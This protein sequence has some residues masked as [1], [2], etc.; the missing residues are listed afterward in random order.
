MINQACQHNTPHPVFISES[1][2]APPPTRMGYL[3]EHSRSSARPKPRTTLSSLLA[4]CTVVT[5]LTFLSALKLTYWDAPPVARPLH[6]DETILKCQAL[7][8][9]P[10]PPADFHQRTVSDRFV[11][12]TKSVLIRNASIWTGEDSGRESIHGDIFIHNGIIQSIGRVDLDSHF[13]D[14]YDAVSIIDAA[15]SWV[16]PGIIDLHSHLGVDSVPELRG[17]SDTNSR[18]GIAQPWLRSLDGLNTRDDAYRLSISGG[19]T[20]AVV[21]PGSANDIGGQ[22]FPIK[23]RPTAER[24]PTS[25]LLEA[26][27]SINDTRVDP[28]APP[29]WRHM[30]YACG[31][32]PMRVY[33]NTRMDNIWA[34]REAHNTARQLKEKQDAYCSKALAG[35]WQGLGEF[36]DDLQWEALVDVLRGRVKVHNHCYETVDLDDL[37]RLTNEFQFPIAAFHH[38]HE[39][40]LVPSTLKKAYGNTP[41]AAIFA[42]NARYKREAYRGS[43]FAARILAD[44]GIDVVMKSDHPVLNSRYL[45]YEAQQAHYYGLPA[46]L[47]LASV[48]S[49]PAKVMGTDHRIGFVREG[50]DADLVLWDSHPLNLGATPQQVWIDGIAQLD[51]PHVSLKTSQLQH[52]PQT[53]NF[54][55]QAAEAVKFEGLQPLSPARTTAETVVFTNVG[56]VFVRNGGRIEEMIGLTD[57]EPGVVVVRKGSIVCQGSHIT[58]ASSTAAVAAAEW[59][60]LKGGSISPGLTSF[61]SP[62]GLQE[63]Q[64]E[65]STYDGWVMDPLLDKIPTI[66]AGAGPI[67]AV[68]GLQ[69]GT[70]DALI[71]YRAG[72]TT[73]VTAPKSRGFLVGY[74]TAFATGAAHKLEEGAVLQYT[75]ALHLSIGHYSSGPSVSTQIAALR[76]F[77]FG[78]AESRAFADIIKGKVPLVI[79]AENAD[80][81][82]TLIQLKQEAEGRT[83]IPIRLTI[84]GASEA[85]MLAKELADEDIGVIVRPSRPFPQ[86]WES[87]RILPGPPL[88]QESN[89]V[90]LLNA[91]V[92]VGIGIEEQWSARNTRFDISWAALESD[93]QITKAE[94]LELAST[95]LEQ[96]LGV[97][98]D[99]T[100]GDMVVTRGGTILDFEGEIVGAFSSRRGVVDFF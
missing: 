35:Q 86:T 49:T 16:T 39:A 98:E 81:I 95:N 56:S 96:L 74:S 37:V 99:T 18:K 27:Y 57:A 25:M 52:A 90:T 63:I 13:L 61:G 94:A 79:E 69:Y 31:E 33:G 36:P 88:T 24:T 93:G 43:E 53:P 91:G 75:T 30:K 3:P 41:A 44:N 55:K 48:I 83:L 32:N 6:A 1:P 73:G 64:G 4:L 66:L 15:G 19:V 9:K 2:P 87:K 28:T 45:L 80:I 82:A 78:A 11:S 22:A 97:A 7:T 92:K 5:S 50:Y 60:D 42:T 65:A 46:N 58:C 84:V 72:V 14:S 68:D 100:G 47:A 76:L 10:G 26:P 23:L 67:H 85:H 12:G 51:D 54:D 71:A 20:T 89:I 62:L 34:F 8:L 21:L 17:S 40:Y 59:L 29:R 77:L 38:A 70:R